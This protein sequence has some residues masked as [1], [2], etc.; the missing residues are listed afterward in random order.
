LQ[1]SLLQTYRSDFGKYSKISSH[2]Y[3]LKVFDSAPRLSGQRLKYV[4]IDSEMRS[5]DLKNA[6]ELLTL[7]GIIKPIYFSSA[8]GLPLGAQLDE[9]KLKL[10]F[11]DTGLM[12][13]VCGLQNQINLGGNI[14]QIDSGSVVEQFVGQELRAY[15][16]KHQPSSLFFWA[17]DIRGS[18]AEVDYIINVDS[19][20]LPVEVKAGKT[21]TLKSLKIFLKE[22]KAKFGVRISKEKLSYYEQV[23]S[24]PLYMIEQIP[25][26]VR[27]V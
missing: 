12:Q 19:E 6:L 4:N 17:R 7:A 2:K 15:S 22:K 25:R 3:L 13:N 16:D 1:N 9:Q 18:S 24:V 10:N 11:L 8:S 14:M 23:L 5:R 21:G 20:I 27:S 26:L